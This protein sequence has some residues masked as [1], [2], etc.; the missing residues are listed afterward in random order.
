MSAALL[1]TL[2]ARIIFVVGKGGVGKSTAAAAIALGLADL[3]HTT[4][5]IS[6]DPAHSI[7]DLFEQPSSSTPVVSDCSDKLV[8]EEFDA[9]QFSRDWL[10]ELRPALI[11]VSERGTYLDAADARGFLDLSL[12]GVDEIMA[13]LRILELI[14]LP[15]ERVVIDTAPTGHLLRLLQAA[16]LLDSWSDALEAIIAKADAVAIGMVGAA[17]QWAAVTLLKRWRAQSTAFTEALQGAQFVVV[18][19]GDAVVAAET[20][21]LLE[22]L[23]RRKFSV[24]AVV[25]NTQPSAL[26]DRFVPQQE[27]APAGCAGLRNWLKAVRPAMKPAA[28]SPT[29]TSQ[30]VARRL[31][32]T[33]FSIEDF[34]TQPLVL[35][36]GKGGVG[37]STV[38][39]A[40]AIEKA[41]SSSTCLVSTDPAGSLADVLGVAVNS[42]PTQVLP[43]LQAWQLAADR[44]LRRL[45]SRYAED[46]HRV[47]EKLGLDQAAPLDRAVIDRLWNLAP[48]GLDEI[49]ALS[50]L[51]SAAERCPEVVLDS[52]PTA[53]FLRLIQ[54]PE[55]TIEWSHALMRLLLKYGVAGAL[56]DFTTE[57]LAFARRTREL[58]ARLTEPDQACAVLVALDEPVV[59]AETARLHAALDRAKIPV[60]ALVVNRTDDGPFR[61]H[62]PV[63]STVR[64]IRAP[65]LETSPIGAD[66]LRDFVRR[67]EVL[68]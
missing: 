48:P 1:N 57:I 31:S 4:H 41:A 38:A 27:P 56:E 12:P 18:T 24:A 22:E 49:V 44:E 9:D 60:A 58:Q 33:T 28:Q 50:E 15:S 6:V 68:T 45:H 7:S 3:E 19:R 47:F 25:A 26:A 30:P 36:A 17:P 43:G 54:L 65:T 63:G 2:S 53:H 8:I 42:D 23:H 55:L 51:T 21:R 11:E 52:A 61:G 59:W 14:Q 66:A 29:Q 13:A 62:P 16:T 39:S 5:V 10:D 64:V 32:S 40:I 34:L 37:K 46:V 67:W 35:V 20:D